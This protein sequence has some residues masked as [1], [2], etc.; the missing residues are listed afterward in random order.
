MTLSQDELQK[1]AKRLTKIEANNPKLLGNI[2]D[3]LNYMKLLEEIDTSGIVPTISVVEENARLREDK[4]QNP[5][6]VTPQELL[7]SSP[8][9]VIADQIVLPNIMS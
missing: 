5:T 3:V 1:I 2:Q 8:Q 9:K 6:G 7:N 4:I